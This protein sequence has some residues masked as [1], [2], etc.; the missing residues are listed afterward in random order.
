[1]NLFSV[2]VLRAAVLGAGLALTALPV[3]AETWR[4]STQTTGDSTEGL[5]IQKFADLVEEYTG[6]AITVQVYPS[7]QLGKLDTVIDQLGQGVLQVVTTSI[8][9]LGKYTPAMDYTS[10]PFLFEDYDQWARF[11]Q[12]DLVEGWITEAEG[13][14]KLAVLGDLAAFPRGSYRVLASNVPVKSLEDIK[15]LRVRQWSQ[16]LQVDVWTH[17]GAEVRILAWAE[18]YDGINRKL[19]QAVTS[20]LELVEPQKFYEVAPYVVRTNE[21]PQALAF[22]VNQ[23]ALDGLTPELRAAVDKAHADAAAYMREMLAKNAEDTVAKLKANGAIFEEM[24]L[25]PVVASMDEFYKGLDAEGKLP[26]GLLDAVI[27][28][29]TATN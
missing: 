5:A 23:K 12:S 29:R 6:G 4:L 24:D 3:M 19:V 1:M 9:F 27:A 16:Q 2:N 22:L 7:E 10:A 11:M 14:A 13:K 18:V 17:L 20:P 15:G 8:G 28:A 25:G 26:A 21:Y